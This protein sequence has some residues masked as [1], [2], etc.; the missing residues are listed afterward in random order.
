MTAVPSKSLAVQMVDGANGPEL[1]LLERDTPK[2]EAEEALVRVNAAGVNPSDVG[3]LSGAF[4]TKLPRVPGRDLAGV[5]VL[6]PVA[7][8]GAEVWAVPAG[9]GFSRDGSHAEYAVVRLEALCKKPASIG[10]EQ[11]AGAGVPYVTAWEGLVNRARVQ[12]GETVLMIGMGSVGVAVAQIARWKGARVIG[13]SSQLPERLARWASEVDVVIDSAPDKLADAVRAATSGR[14]VDVVFN[15]VGSTT[16]APSLEVAAPG[17]R[18]VA[19]AASLPREVSFDLLSLYRRGLSLFGI[20]TLAISDTDSAGILGMLA[21]GFDQ[22]RLRVSVDRTFP[23]AD[24]TRAYAAVR[25][26]GL[27]KIVLAAQPA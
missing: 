17:A 14:G 16:F 11:A 2:P 9:S 23:F 5:V 1:F 22:G 27:G 18:L 3:N 10:F 4:G 19:I 6:G 21:Q 13:A 7:W 26:R 8:A 12:P 20:N 15:A 25:G 24:A